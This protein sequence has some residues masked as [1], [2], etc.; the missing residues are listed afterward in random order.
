MIDK[1]SGDSFVDHKEEMM[2]AISE[3]EKK[4][5][6][7]TSSTY[8]ACTTCTTKA[9]TEILKI[10]RILGLVIQQS[11]PSPSSD[12]QSESELQQIET[13]LNKISM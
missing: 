2:K 8:N 3:R 11:E 6:I 1:V 5:I 9:K 7:S 13:T 10:K 12:Y 4:V